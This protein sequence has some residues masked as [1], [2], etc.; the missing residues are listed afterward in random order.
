MCNIA[1]YK[2]VKFL[3]TKEK[4]IKYIK[5]KITENVLIDIRDRKLSKP[6]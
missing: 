5:S 1:N 2:N 4:T 6:E 3:Q